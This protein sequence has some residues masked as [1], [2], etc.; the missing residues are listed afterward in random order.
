M[1]T[2]RVAALLAV[3][4]VGLG[5]AGTVDAWSSGLAWLVALAMLVMVALLSMVDLA[6]AAPISARRERHRQPDRPQWITPPDAGAA[7]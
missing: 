5:I 3:G 1:I 2:R 7:A 6:L 4:A